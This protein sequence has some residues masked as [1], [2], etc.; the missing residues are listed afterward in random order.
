MLAAALALGLSSAPALAQSASPAAPAD[1][2]HRSGINARE[3]R[4]RARIRNGVQDGSLTTAEARRLRT[5]EAGIR[6][7][8]RAFRRSG[9]GLNRVER[10]DLQR[11]LN[12]TSRQIRRLTHNGRG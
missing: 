1:S 2:A 7:E 3:A 8:E 5:E 9:D 6:A 11:D 12:Q 4:Q 10:R